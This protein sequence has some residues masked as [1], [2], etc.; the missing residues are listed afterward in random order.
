M[1]EA[2]RP[3]PS[4]KAGAEPF[5]ARP[6]DPV[7]ERPPR[8]QL[9]ELARRL[10]TAAVLIPLVLWVVVEGGL[11]FLATVMAFAL[12]GQREFY[13]LIEEVKAEGR[14]VFISSHNLPDLEDIFLSYC[15]EEEGERHVA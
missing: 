13:R 5:H 14:T 4:E 11:P 12:L 1:S 7:V 9:S 6:P 10:V 15:G 2:E 8:R 3:Q